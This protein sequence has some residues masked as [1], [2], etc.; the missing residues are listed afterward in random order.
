MKLENE[1]TVN[2]PIDRVWDAMLDLEEVTPCLPGA[3]L[4]EQRGDEYKACNLGVDAR[5]GDDRSAVGMPDE[6]RRTVL[7]VQ[8]AV[9]G[10]HVICERGQRVLTDADT[11][12]A[13][14]EDVVHAAPAR[15]VCKGAVNE[16]DGFDRLFGRD[17]LL[18]VCAGR[19][20]RG[21]GS[22]GDGS[23]E[24]LGHL[25]VPLVDIGRGP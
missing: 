2:T 4:T 3:Q 23:S 19:D 5:L 18:R 14:G 15:A 10:S 7:T 25:N 13:R 20:G 8:D 16:D 24:F 1:F 9:G 21:G 17:R 11:V 22:G 12:A 6:Y